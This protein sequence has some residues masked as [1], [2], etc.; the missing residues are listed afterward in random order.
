MEELRI[1]YREHWWNYG[2]SLCKEEHMSERDVVG[3]LKALMKTKTQKRKSSKSLSSP[4]SLFI[5]LA[6]QH[7]NEVKRLKMASMEKLVM[8]IALCVLSALTTATRPMK[9]P[10]TVEGKVYYDTCHAGYETKAITYIASAKIQAATV[11]VSLC[12][13][14]ELKVEICFG[15]E[16]VR[17]VPKSVSLVMV[18]N[19]ENRIKSERLEFDW[20]GPQVGREQTAKK[21]LMIN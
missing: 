10:F 9:T 19:E 8:L 14:N 5:Y 16:L 2:V 13:E 17:L 3:M 12:N 21:V 11:L 20:V 18:N 1:G 6:H 4:L 7:F 15:I